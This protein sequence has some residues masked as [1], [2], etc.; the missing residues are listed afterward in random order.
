MT[1]IRL[2]KSNQEKIEKL[3]DNVLVCEK[4]VYKA[5]NKG[6]GM[7]NVDPLKERSM[8]GHSSGGG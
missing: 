5:S 7:N 8:N 6:E 4:G 1:G 3:F 2:R